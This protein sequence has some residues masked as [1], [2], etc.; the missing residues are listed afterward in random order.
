M[1]IASWLFN[2]KMVQK[3]ISPSNRVCKEDCRQPALLTGHG[4]FP[5]SAQDRRVPGTA[6]QLSRVGAKSASGQTANWRAYCGMSAVP[7]KCDEARW[8]GHFAEGPEAKNGQTGTTT[9]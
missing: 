2:S 6:R 8:S 7:S 4:N 3:S 5:V 9:S 1:R